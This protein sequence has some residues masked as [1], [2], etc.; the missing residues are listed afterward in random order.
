MDT[1]EE[2]R[3][4]KAA[5]MR[6][7][8]AA[9][10]ERINAQRR[11]KREANGDR[12]LA[13]E[14]VWRAAN[15]EK[16][17][18]YK[19]GD[20]EKRPDDYARWKRDWGKRHRERITEKRRADYQ[21]NRHEINAR[22]KAAYEADPEGHRKRK[23]DMSQRRRARL[24]GAP[25]ERIDRDVIYDRDGGKC[26]ICGKHVKRSEMSIDHIIPIVYGGPHLMSNVR[27]AHIRCNKVRGHRGAAQMRLPL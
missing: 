26:Q 5:Y 11:A 18:V 20:R 4:K 23:A 13:V 27:L 1:P 15:H 16:V 2:K 14:K 22:I 12:K 25:T 8:T 17:L 21:K 10:N 7:Y 24:A 19:K 6:Q 9:N 3:R